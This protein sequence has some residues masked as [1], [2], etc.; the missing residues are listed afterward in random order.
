MIVAR[1]FRALVEPRS[2]RQ[3][4]VKNTVWLSAAIGIAG[5]IDF[6]LAVYVIR[7]FGPLEYGKF[8]YAL[9]FVAL[10]SAAL[11][12]GLTTAVTREFARDP[13]AMRD[14]PAILILKALISLGAVGALVGLSFIV[15]RDVTVRTLIGLL[16]LY[17]FL[18]ESL[19]LFHA[20]FRSQQ[21]MEVEAVVRVTQAALLGCAVIFVLRIRPSVVA[22]A[23]GYAAAVGVTLALVTLWVVGRRRFGP[24]RLRWD[25]AVLR[26]FAAIG[27][28]LALAKVV[29]D[30]TAN[31]DSV[32]LGSW[33]YLRETGWYNAAAK[34]QG[35]ALFPMS[36]VSTAIFPVLVGLRRDSSDRF[37]GLW[38]QWAQGTV[39]FVVFLAGAL[40]A[41][42]DQVVT[43]LYPAGFRP[44]VLV[45]R[46]LILKLVVLYA[47][48]L[49]Y[50]ALL[51]FD[52]QRR[53]FAAVLVGMAVNVVLNILL[54]P[55]YTLYGAAAAAAAAHGVILVQYLI[56]AGR[57][58][59][60]WSIVPGLRGTLGV[61]LLAAG[62]AY[63]GL[64]GLKAAGINIIVSLSAAAAIYA[65]VTA[66]FY[67][68]WKA[69][70][71]TP[72]ASRGVD[73][74]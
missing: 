52:Q 22:L 7:T 47:H 32:L 71:T 38:G 10:F 66:G 18:L 65:A 59:T 27:L 74:P 73:A 43:V 45:L 17:Y 48:N 8:T 60:V 15:T 62:L 69:P 6:V 2:H 4:I 39:I 14:F 31:T 70:A 24:M 16:G 49:F 5:L 41:T 51:V 25:G 19:N 58:T 42:A 50:H 34:I 30:V 55:R 46:I 29:G 35:M 64:T 40:W 53:V 63:A 26:K 9:A 23:A 11:D 3:V 12:F 33:G 21:R 28:F 67:R 13:G 68:A 61:S 1:L 37:L 57:Y 20:V 56:L 44:A 36:L 54:I 72:P